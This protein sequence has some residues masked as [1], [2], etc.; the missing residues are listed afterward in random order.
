MFHS[1]AVRRLLAPGMPSRWADEIDHLEIKERQ[2][3]KLG[4]L[5]LT[6]MLG[7][8]MAVSAAFGQEEVEQKQE[9]SVQ[10][11]GSFVK[12]TT[13]NG[14]QQ[15]ATNTAGVLANYRYFFNRNNGVEVNYAFTGDTQRFGL[16]GGLSGI[17]NRTHELSAAYVLRF[18]H[19]RISP[20]ALA[21]A[22]SLIFDPNNLTGGSTQAR[23]AF[24]Y[25][26]GADIN[27]SKHLFLRGEYRG[28][29][30]NTPTYG[31]VGLAGS[32][33]ITHEAEPSVGFG[34]RF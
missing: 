23:A 21:G 3:M 19:K 13:Q 33:R 17:D 26:A 25:G 6:T 2:T 27:V 15:D 20:F 9:I 22:G 11:V 8:A 31:L 29:V 34:W 5:V 28:L 4:Q 14:I 18:P 30:Y 16:G 32:D 7:S 10:A 24:V 1:L 12:S